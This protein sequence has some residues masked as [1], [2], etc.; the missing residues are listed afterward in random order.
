M[1]LMFQVKKIQNLVAGEK[2]MLQDRQVGGGQD[3]RA[4]RAGHCADP[5]QMPRGPGRLCHVQQQM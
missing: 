4:S 3:G 1:M 2:S 5:A